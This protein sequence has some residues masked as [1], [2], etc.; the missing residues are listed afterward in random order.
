MNADYRNGSSGG[1]MDWWLVRCHGESGEVVDASIL[2]LL[3]FGFVGWV[4]AWVGNETDTVV[5]WL[6]GGG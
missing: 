1:E 6:G 5:R 4:V 2:A 3:S